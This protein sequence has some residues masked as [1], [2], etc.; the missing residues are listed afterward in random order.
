MLGKHHL[1][2][3]PFVFYFCIEWVTNWFKFRCL[4]FKESSCTF[5]RDPVFSLRG[6]E[7]ELLLLD[8]LGCTTRALFSRIPTVRIAFQPLFP[9]E[10]L[11]APR[12]ET[13]LLW[14][15]TVAQKMNALCYY[16]GTDWGDPGFVCVCVSVVTA[17]DRCA[18]FWE[19]AAA[20]V[21][22]EQIVQ[23][24]PKDCHVA[25]SP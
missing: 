17:P 7:K 24:S 11:P 20:G 21:G 9:S 12:V 10:V 22:G 3:K 6:R 15:E 8:A 18:P 1:T 25:G 19:A 13:F 4:R 23:D 5:Q 16:L 2:L 14:D